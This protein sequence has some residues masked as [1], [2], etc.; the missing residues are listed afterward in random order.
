MSVVRESFFMIPLKTGADRGG[1]GGREDRES[2]VQTCPAATTYPNSLF[3]RA[4]REDLR[5][6]ETFLI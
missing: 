1:T 2:P 3:I 6:R 4:Q 5:L